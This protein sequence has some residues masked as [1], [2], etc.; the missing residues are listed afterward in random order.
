MCISAETAIHAGIAFL[1]VEILRRQAW[2]RRLQT[3]L[4]VA[5]LLR[6]TFSEPWK[7]EEIGIL[8]SENQKGREDALSFPGRPRRWDS[9]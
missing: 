6:A 9:S 8:A 5:R 7:Q 3:R 4:F 2:R 1:R